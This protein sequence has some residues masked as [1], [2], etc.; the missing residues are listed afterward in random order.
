M[1]RLPELLSSDSSQPP[2]FR[3]LSCPGESYNLLPKNR[4]KILLLSSFWVLTSFFKKSVKLSPNSSAYLFKFPVLGASFSL[5]APR[6]PS[7][8]GRVSSICPVSH[9]VHTNCSC[10]TGPAEARSSK[11]TSLVK[12]PWTTL[13]HADGSLPSPSCGLFHRI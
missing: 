12:L 6:A 7:Y 8:L 9:T 11:F 2:N 10:D 1:S 3:S 4:S 13:V 5:L